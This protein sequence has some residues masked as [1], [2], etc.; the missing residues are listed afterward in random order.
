[1]K[2]PDAL[3]YSEFALRRLHSLTG[4]IPLTGFIYFHFFENSYSAKGLIAYNKTVDELRGLPFLKGIEWTL[5]LGPFL[6]HMFYGLWRTYT[7]KPNCFRQ[8]YG[9]NWAFLFQRIT[10]IIVFVFVI[11]HV[12][13]LRFFEPA[14]DPSTGKLNYYSYL[15]GH[16]QNPFVYGFYV[17]G[18][19][20]TAF[21]LAN[22]VC[23]FCM[24]WGITIS[25]RSQQALA[26]AMIIGGLLAFTMGIYALR[27]F[28]SPSPTAPEIVKPP[29][30]MVQRAGTK[31]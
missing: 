10:A 25:R 24:T 27:G 28:N 16:F 9:R 23:T 18:I 13:G 29:V 5:L 14:L 8:N 12:V 1:M 26:Y 2:R 3:G 22:G 17:V 19:A 20:A 4:L 7:T 21:H 6:F 31:G 11:Y 30:T 15:R